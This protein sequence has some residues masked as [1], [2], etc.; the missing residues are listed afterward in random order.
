MVW[1][2]VQVKE[3]SADQQV[4]HTNNHGLNPTMRRPNIDQKLLHR[5]QGEDPRDEETKDRIIIYL[6]QHFKY[7]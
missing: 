3:F 4:S 7:R 1:S 6:D 5:P 2:V